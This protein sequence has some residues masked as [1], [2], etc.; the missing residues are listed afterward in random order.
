MTHE[1]VVN[2]LM[3]RGLSAGWMHA[4]T[5]FIYCHGRASVARL[6]GNGWMCTSCGERVR[7][8]A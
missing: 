6:T 2:R 7:V 1:D 5:T 3:E 8:V 4:E